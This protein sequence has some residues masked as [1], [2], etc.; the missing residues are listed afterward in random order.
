MNIALAHFNRLLKRGGYNRL[1]LIFA[2]VKIKNG[3]NRYSRQKNERGYNK[4]NV[5]AYVGFLEK[6]AYFFNCH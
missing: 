4:K 5:V 2:V 6:S 1:N 3:N